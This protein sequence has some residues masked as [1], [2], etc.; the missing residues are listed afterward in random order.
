MKRAKRL[1]RYRKWR[2]ILWRAEKV[3]FGTVYPHPCLMKFD[4]TPRLQGYIDEVKSQLGAKYE[5]RFCAATELYP[6]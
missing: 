1:A 3:V 5:C 6:E 2:Q 4:E